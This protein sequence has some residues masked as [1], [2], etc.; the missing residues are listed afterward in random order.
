MK[1]TI[2]FQY[3]EHAGV[4]LPLL[5]KIAKT[6]TFSALRVLLLA[7]FIFTNNTSKN[8]IYCVITN[9]EMM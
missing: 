7:A 4:E 9:V 2:M 3:V 8:G 1:A 6:K 5:L